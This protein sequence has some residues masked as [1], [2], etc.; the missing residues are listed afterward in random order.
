[1]VMAALWKGEGKIQ[2]EFGSVFMEDDSQMLENSVVALN[3]AAWERLKP[4]LLKQDFIDMILDI[5]S[6]DDP[7]GL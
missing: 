7:L 3:V 5:Y 4:A 6:G 2:R 1:M